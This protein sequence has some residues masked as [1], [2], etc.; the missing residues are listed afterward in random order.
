MHSIR[1][2]IFFGL[3]F[4]GA[5]RDEGLS[6]DQKHILRKLLKEALEYV[7]EEEVLDFLK[8]S[9]YFRL[10]FCLY[11]PLES[12]FPEPG[13][14]LGAHT[15]SQMPDGN[16]SPPT[17]RPGAKQPNFVL[18]NL[19]RTEPV[20]ETRTTSEAGQSS[21]TES[22]GSTQ[23][24]MPDFPEIALKNAIASISSWNEIFDGDVED[25]PSEE[26]TGMNRD[27]S[28][29][30]VN[31]YD[32]LEQSA[33]LEGLKMLGSLEKTSLAKSISD[34]RGITKLSQSLPNGKQSTM[35]D[36]SDESNDGAVGASSDGVGKA[37]LG[38]EE[39]L[40]ENSD[41]G[42]F[43]SVIMID[44]DALAD[45][46]KTGTDRVDHSLTEPNEQLPL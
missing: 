46:E 2:N 15:P 1:G 43:Q 24:D 33:G 9:L 7:D 10:L 14:S 22:I 34:N 17:D 3:L 20:N 31:G 11:N 13:P 27:S 29:F 32:P 6:P 4:L 45:E 38:G 12:P 16:A 40:T 26:G 5:K 39:S 36:E 18:P 8:S 41:E 23:N 19:S 35:I 37:A 28:K 25:L 21:T 30:L 44:Y 42:E